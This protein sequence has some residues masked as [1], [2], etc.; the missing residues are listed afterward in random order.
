MMRI[1]AAGL[2]CAALAACGSGDGSS[3]A[4][5]TAVYARGDESRRLDPAAT[6]WGSDAM[7]IES[8]FETLVRF[9]DRGVDLVAGL[10]ESWERAA[11]GKTWT[12]RLRSGV[13]FHD[14]TPFGS[15]AVKFTLERLLGVKPHAPP[16]V[17]YGELYKDISAIETPDP[18]TVILKL[19]RPSEVLLGCLA[20]FPAS[21]VSPEAVKKHGDQFA[22]NPVGTG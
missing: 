12:F 1:L 20:M 11:D 21:I 18:R 7:I 9:S 15:D 5:S 10:A 19:A 16:Q 14:G 2:A 13:T 22:R 6:E 17:P 3:A 8:V 4:E